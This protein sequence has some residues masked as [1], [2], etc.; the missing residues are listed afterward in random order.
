MPR[1]VALPRH[2]H[3]VDILVEGNRRIIVPAGGTWTEFF[4]SDAIDDDFLTDRDQP[5]PQRRGLK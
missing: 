4:S 5:E 1:A 2:V 3:H